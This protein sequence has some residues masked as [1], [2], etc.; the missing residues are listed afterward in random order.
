MSDS[1]LGA[2]AASMFWLFILLMAVVGFD[3]ATKRKD[4]TMK[5][6]IENGASYDDCLKA[7]NGK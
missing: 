6:C 3:D 2:L 5:I 4:R 1:A 7:W